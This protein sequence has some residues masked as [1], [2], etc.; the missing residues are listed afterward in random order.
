MIDPRKLRPG[1]M[2]RLLNSTPAGEVITERQ[3]RRYR[4]RAG[5]RLGEGPHLDFLR[6]VAWVMEVR[7]GPKPEPGRPAPPPSQ[8]TE[9]ALGAAALASRHEQLKGH[10]QK[11]TRKQEALIASLLS[12][13]TYT[14]AAAKARVG[15]ASLYR[16]LE[17]PAFRA[18]YHQAGREL[19]DAA[20]GRIQAAS[21]VAVDALVEVIRESRRDGDRIRAANAVLNHAHRGLAAAELLHGEQETGELEQQTP[22]GAGKDFSQRFSKGA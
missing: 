7:H 14:A 4:T 19:F 17:L 21:G 22:A 16:W 3:L 2:C 12:E 10:G 8:L 11:F 18:A 6:F 20:I 1:E 9:A 15:R 5:L 13:P